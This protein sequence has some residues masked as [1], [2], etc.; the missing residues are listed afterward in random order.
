[1]SVLRWCFVLSYQQALERLLSQVPPPRV[2]Q[3][4]LLASRGRVLAELVRADRDLPPFPKAFMDGYAL[5]S[6]DGS[7]VSVRLRVIG[8]V[9]AGSCGLPQLEEGQ[10]VQIM[11]GAPLPPGADAVQVVEKTRKLD[12]NSLEILEA[13]RKGDNIALQGD[14]ISAGEMVLQSGRIIASAE[15]GVLATFGVTQVKVYAGPGVAIVSTGDEIVEIDQA[16]GFAQI[17]NSNAY[18]LWSQCASLGLEAEILPVVPDDLEKTRQS[19]LAGL[20]RELILFTGGVSM[21][22]HDYVQRALREAGFEIFFTKWRSSRENRFWSE[23]GGITWS[24]G[25]PAIQCPLL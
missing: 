4:P 6:Q 10:A 23:K 2:V 9:T 19:A 12:G 5:R 20:Q 8:K 16:P 22:E 21:A 3:V 14:E 15:I 11:T 25:C 13:V 24:L 17:R 7:R 18:T 1:M